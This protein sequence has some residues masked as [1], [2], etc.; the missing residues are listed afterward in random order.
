MSKEIRF[1]GRTRARSHALQLLFQAESRS[2]R[3][4]DIINAHYLITEGP[5]EEFA[6]TLALGADAVR[7]KLDALIA[8]T[9]TNWN[10]TRLL[11]VDRNI[12]RL[13][14]FEM[15][16]VDDVDVAVTINEFVILAKA[17]GTDD[18]AAFVNGVLGQVARRLSAGEDIAHIYGIVPPQS[19]E[20]A[21][22]AANT[23]EDASDASGASGAYASA[24]KHMDVD[25]MLGLSD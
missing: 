23:D 9:A 11:S 15:L 18:S 3:V 6:R 24:D 17:Y 22:V 7:D 19:A 1:I 12:I 25:D 16:H 13:A 14:L 10:V 21:S 4:A 2:M 5:L 20:N 8:D